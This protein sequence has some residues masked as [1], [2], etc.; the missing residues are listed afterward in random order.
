MPFIFLIAL[1]ALLSA[2]AASAFPPNNV[3]LPASEVSSKTLSK[4]SAATAPKGAENKKMAKI[5]STVVISKTSVVSPKEKFQL[6]ISRLRADNFSILQGKRVG[7]LTHAA[8]VDEN[9]VSTID[10][11]LK[12]PGVK[13]VA[14]YAPEHGLDGQTKAEEK[15]DDRRFDGLPVYSLYGGTRKPKPE[16]LKEIDCMVIDLQDIGVRSYTYISAMKYTMEACFEQKI[17]VV[18]LDRPNPLGGLKVDGPVLDPKFQSYVGFYEIPYIHGLTIGELA[19]VAQ[20]ELA[21]PLT[22]S[23]REGEFKTGLRPATPSAGGVEKRRVVDASTS[24]VDFN[25]RRRDDG[26]TGS[27][28]IIKMT[29]WRR[30]MLWS[31][32]GLKWCATS[33]S[34]PTL[35]AAFGY[36]CT[37]LGAQL[38]GF[39]HGYG[40]EYPFRFLTY[41]KLSPVE[42]KRRLDRAHL[43]GFSFE[44]TT[45]KKGLRGEGEEGVYVRV[46]NW[47]AASP[48]ALSLTML[49]IAQEQEGSAP[50]V[51]PSLSTQDLFCKHWGRA[52]PLNTLRSGK[53][54]NAYRLS[55]YWQV[56]A[57]R[58]QSKAVK[59]WLY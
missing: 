55:H 45:I 30:G 21:H 47:N 29:G 39:H 11:L 49:Q 46:N 59:Y 14:L 28:T 57:A 36:A 17:P 31:D 8:A 15:V 24:A 50:F 37:G 18:V 26:I 6:G 54:L 44:V 9:G 20:D 32:T 5:S 23:L 22:P 25:P 34:V 27:L 48:I 51:S 3:S 2:P 56:Q 33:P 13:L 4:G 53:R 35:G 43:P 1:I 52:E 38:G 10:I 41:N 40:T 58:W 19:L 12:A 42:L 7:L 16:M